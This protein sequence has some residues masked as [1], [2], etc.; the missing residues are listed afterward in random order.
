MV[1]EPPIHSC[2]HSDENPTGQSQPFISYGAGF[3]QWLTEGAEGSSS[4][5]CTQQLTRTADNLQTDEGH[6]LQHEFSTA[7]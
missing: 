1:W 4:A 5:L 3:M 6:G 2:F 7:W